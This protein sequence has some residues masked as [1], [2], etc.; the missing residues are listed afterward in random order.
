MATKRLNRKITS[1]NT[2]TRKV[3]KKV[4]SLKKEVIPVEKVD[5]T[6]SYQQVSKTAKVL[7]KEVRQAINEIASD[8]VEN[9]IIIGKVTVN[10]AAKLTTKFNKAVSAKNIKKTTEQ[11]KKASVDFNE[12]TL[13][14]AEDIL[15]GAIATGEKWQTVTN[16]AIKGGLKLAAKQQNMMFDTLDA[17]KG[18]FSNNVVR[19]KKF[20]SKN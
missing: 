5:F 1:K 3:A 10:E 8:L 4:T 20:F 14:T 12:Y 2:A 11:I 9:S 7:N 17:V 19:M 6:D 15:D 18:Q 13:T 16:K